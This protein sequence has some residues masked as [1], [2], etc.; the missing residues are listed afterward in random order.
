MAG[1]TVDPTSGE[2][3][4]INTT[5][6]PLDAVASALSTVDGWG[7]IV[8]VINRWTQ[9]VSGL[10]AAATRKGGLL[11][12]DRFV[13]PAT[14]FEKMRT[15]RHAIRDDVVGG[16]ADGSEAI[17][18]SKL[19]ISCPDTEQ[20]DV[21]NQWA[22]DIDLDDRLRTH[23]R[24]LFKYSQ[25]VIATWWDERVYRVRR[26]TSAG[27]QARK[28][29][30][31][32]VPTAIT[33]IDPAK[34]TPVGSLM[35]GQ[36][37]L[38]YVADHIEAM[39][40]DQIL[41]ARD[42]TN[43][44]INQIDQGQLPPSLRLRVRGRGRNASLVQN[45]PTGNV[46]DPIVESL[47]VGRYVPDF[48][49]QQQLHEDGV[50]T[51]HLFLLNPE[52]VFRHT[53]TRADY[54]RFAQVR[55]ESVFELLDL[56]SQ[57]RQMDRSHLL[58]GIN[59]LI[60]IRK[61]TDEH[62]ANQ[63][64]ISNLRA[65]AAGMMSTPLIVGDHRLQVDIVTPSLDVTLT[66]S[67]Y[68]TLD[69][70]LFARAWG[71]FVPTGADTDDPVKLGRVIA[72]NL[73][74]RRQ[75]MRRSWE[76]NIFEKIREQNPDQLTERA[77]LQFKPRRISL[78]FDQGMAT[79]LADLRAGRTI[80]RQSL[81]DLFDL[82]QADEALQL[83]REAEEYDAIF[84]EFNPYGPQ[85]PGVGD[86]PEPTPSQS[87][88]R[89]R[90]GGRQGGGNRNGGGAAPGSGQGQE[91]RNPRTRSGGGRRARLNDTGTPVDENDEEG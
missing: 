87:G 56:K 32:R 82:S 28:K 15:A 27:N 80:S 70:R 86:E 90:A 8:D 57:L 2:A 25:C 12:R 59:F 85:A 37:R 51:D 29:F 30:A 53:L 84:R 40:F 47:I 26:R 21:W 39:A 41:A 9:R 74:S 34:V 68:D 60:V 17:T 91:P 48:W 88:A 52:L 73:Q 19:S 78:T 22:A 81:L 49:E 13:T 16:A 14:P 72:Q 4:V 71:T 36:E 1:V 64:E 79:L 61:G 20:E 18:L 89:R 69:V 50:Q 23:W 10:P 63:A 83:E 66:R 65:N 46:R 67:K 6:V 62:P 76:H 33:F 58:G 7:P 3:V 55:L 42:G 24:E 38:A 35:F 31:L 43:D 54:E 77:K 75:M 5:G 45:A 44:P 11:E